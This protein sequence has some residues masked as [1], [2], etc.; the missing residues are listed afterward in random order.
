MSNVNL[1]IIK[2]ENELMEKELLLRTFVEIQTIAQLLVAK[3]IISEEEI[4][5]TRNII[6][7][8]PNIKSL[9]DEVER[10]ASTLEYFKN[11]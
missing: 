3:N 1:E 5:K 9:Y 8:T 11:H 7:T 2:S 10:F 4:F 6:K